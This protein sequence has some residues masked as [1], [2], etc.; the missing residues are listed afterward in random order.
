MLLKDTETEFLKAGTKKIRE[1]VAVYLSAM[2]Y[3]FI[4]KYFRK[5]V[6]NPSIL[7]A[8]TRVSSAANEQEHF[9]FA[10]LSLSVIA[11]TLIT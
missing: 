9:R 3:A 6:V 7:V 11:S 8:Q 5:A 4:A 2:G 10:L 1:A